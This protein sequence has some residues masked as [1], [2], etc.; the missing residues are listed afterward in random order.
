[1]PL[2]KGIHFHWHHAGHT[3]ILQCCWMLTLLSLPPGYFTL[4]K[5]L[6]K[7]CYL[8]QFFISLS[9]AVDYGK[10][11]SVY[12]RLHDASSSFLL[13][14]LRT[15]SLALSHIIVSGTPSHWK[16]MENALWA[17]IFSFNGNEHDQPK[18]VAKIHPHLL[19]LLETVVAN[20]VSLHILCGNLL[21]CN[22]WS[23]VLN[24]LEKDR[25]NTV[26]TPCY[27]VQRMVVL[28][29]VKYLTSWQEPNGQAQLPYW[30]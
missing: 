5:H 3:L 1:M 18:L 27:V 25:C 14:L 19:P 6:S 10:N 7:W 8:I 20:N 24:C 30:C 13:N 4:L 16:R 12:F 26:Q 2:I 21:Y 29:W 28:S 17:S 22:W 11:I 9:A 23:C 15:I